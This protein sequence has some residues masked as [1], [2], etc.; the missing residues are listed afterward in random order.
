[1]KDPIQFEGVKA[2]LKQSKE[3]Y[4]LTMAIHPDDICDDLMRDF[5]GARYMVVMVRIGDN[6]QPINRE[7]EFAGDNAVKVAGILCRD[8]DFW[9]WLYANEYCMEKNE[10]AAAEWLTDYLGL[11]S[12]KE[13]KTNREAREL[14]N[15]IKESFNKWNNQ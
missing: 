10:K 13:L 6:E 12:R 15:K 11:E 3:G 8:K 5:V 14:F 7:G 9:D 2:G 1:M 4:I